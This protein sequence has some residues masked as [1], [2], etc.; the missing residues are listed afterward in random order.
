MVGVKVGGE[1]R[2]LVVVLSGSPQ[3]RDAMVMHAAERVG[4]IGTIHVFSDSSVQRRLLCRMSWLSAFSN[5]DWN[6]YFDDAVADDEF[7]SAAKILAPL[8]TSWTW[9]SMP[10]RV[11]EAAALRAEEL[12]VPL[13]GRKS[14]SRGAEIFREHSRLLK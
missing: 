13:L 1:C 11:H 8:G 14:R 6:I 7:T 9:E 5:V 4:R 2:D 10:W 12:G 3:T